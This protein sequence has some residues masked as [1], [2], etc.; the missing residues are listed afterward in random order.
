MSLYNIYCS[1]VFQVVT[2]FSV[3]L[4]TFFIL[5]EQ[6]PQK[7]YVLIKR[8][9]ITL[10]YLSFQLCIQKVLFSDITQEAGCVDWYFTG[11]ALQVKQKLFPSIW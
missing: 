5:S 10:G 3:Y 11:I 9:N 8:S 6:V 2:R 1:W 4:A 7:S